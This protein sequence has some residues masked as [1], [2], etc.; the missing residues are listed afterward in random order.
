MGRGMNMPAFA[1]FDLNADGSLTEQEFYEARTKRMSER[2]Q[3]GFAMRNA[4][5]APSF[6]DIDR[7]GDG[8]VGPEDFREALEAHHRGWMSQQ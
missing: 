6:E 3:Q 7:D 4:P 8:S 1:E 2:A 5:N